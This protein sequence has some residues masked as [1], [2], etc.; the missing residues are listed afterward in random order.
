MNRQPPR[1][2][3]PPAPDWVYFGLRALIAGLA[4]MLW[5]FEITGRE[6]LPA[7]GGF[8]VV[9][10]HLS[11]FD[12]VVGFL[13]IPQRLLG[14]GADKWRRV[15]FTRMLLETAGVIWVARGEA[16]MD[17]LKATL[18]ALKA[19][20]RLGFAP[21]GTRS[22]TRTL[23]RGKPGA[24]Y[25][26]DRTR[27][28]IV[29]LAITG[30]ENVIPCWKRLRRPVVRGVIGEPFRLPGKGRA[31]AA[32]LDDLTDLIMVHIAELLPPAYRG[33]YADH[34]RLQELLAGQAT[35]AQ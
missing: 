14:F 22:L 35:P 23:Q 2:D 20:R 1:T 6:H 17:A 31:K 24:A 26:A 32:E 8:I 27:A 28:L 5:R 9:I 25:L 10:N 18:A 7:S 34:P 13:A 15:W 11:T 33:A 12:A 16:D 29:P 3:P 21:E 19:G 30:T 4:R